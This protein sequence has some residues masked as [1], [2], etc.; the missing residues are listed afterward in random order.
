MRIGMFTSGYQRYPLEK[1]FADSRRFGYDYVELWGGRPHAFPMDLKAGEQKEVLNLV[2]KYEM[3][4]EIYT[5]E[6]N[7]YPYNYMMG[8]ALQW[9]DSM[10]YLET[11]LE[12]GKA[13]G[14]EYTLISAGHAGNLATQKEIRKRLEKSLGRLCAYAEKIDTKIILEPLTAF[15]TNVCTSANELV[16][17]L[18]KID[19]RCLTG[20]CDIVVPYLRHEPIMSYFT[21]LGTRMNH[22]HLQDSDGI[23]ELHVL[24]GEGEAPLRE[25]LEEVI[26][27]GYHGRM[28]IELVTAYINEPSFY[29]R[30]AIRWVKEQLERIECHGLED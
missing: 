24:P 3:P 11:A 16:E 26:Q 18:D 23:S 19:S 9:E 4:V 1:A 12:M 28:T 13:L 15:E 8:S 22:L 10:C 27:I 7:G 21:K 2:D 25:L 29:A 17:I 20:M 30:R 5:P 14:A 6:H